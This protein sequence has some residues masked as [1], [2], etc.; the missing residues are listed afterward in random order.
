MQTKRIA[1]LGIFLESNAFAAVFTRR[2]FESNIYMEDDAISLDARSQYPRL[3]KEVVGFYRD[4]DL[5]SNWEPVP[6]LITYAGAGGPADHE[7]ILNTFN[8]IRNKLQTALPVDGVYIAEHG[9]MTTTES[10]DPDGELFAMVREVVGPNVPVVATIDLH[11]NVSQRM[12]DNVDVLVSYRADPHVDRAER[13]EEAAAI[14]REMFGGMHPVVKNIR[15]PI[16]PPNIS[17]PTAEGPYGDLIKYGQSRM[18][19]EIVNVS[20][21]AGFAFSDTSKNGLHVIVTAREDGEA[22]R[23]LCVDLAQRGWADR[24]RFMWTNLTSIEKAIEMA[25][26]AGEDPSRPALIMADLGDNIGAGGPGNT[27]WMLEALYNAGAKGALIAD[28]CDPVLATKAHEAGLGAS[29]NA[30]FQGDDWDRVENQFYAPVRVRSLHNGQSVGR[31]GINIGR[32][33]DTGPACLLEIGSMMITVTSRRVYCMDPVFVERMG[34]DVRE[35]R[36]LVV[37]TRGSYK[38]AFDE[39]FT[40]SQMI[41]VDTPGRT[42]PV[43]T[44]Y[45]WKNLPRPVYPLDQDFEWSVPSIS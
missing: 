10:E 35:L 16:V 8:V 26:A 39:F 3:M 4:M 44:R 13:G 36:T 1:I 17:L 30:V 19:P 2:D 24:E 40:P 41:Q 12:V 14:L 33:M 20:V 21:V 43:L 9:A 38:V 5:H 27:L 15:L 32:S 31:H 18:T 7:F 45:P 25:V 11:A 37:G 42:S 29:F 34:L 22:A 23:R 6:L 28:F